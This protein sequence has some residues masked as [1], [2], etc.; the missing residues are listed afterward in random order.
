[1]E[2]L[3]PP[4]DKVHSEICMHSSAAASYRSFVGDIF[5]LKQLKRFAYDARVKVQSS[6]SG[7]N[8]AR[9]VGDIQ[10]GVSFR[11]VNS[12]EGIMSRVAYETGRY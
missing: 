4:F 12:F 2:R 10:L 9:Y 3:F 7:K 11:S 6:L 5:T 1:M 8:T